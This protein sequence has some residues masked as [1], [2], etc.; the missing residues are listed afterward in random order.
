MCGCRICSSCHRMKRRLHPG[1][2]I[3]RHTALS[4]TEDHFSVLIF[5]ST[6]FCQAGKDLRLS[7]L[8][9]DPLDVPPGFMLVGV[10]S[11]S[12][13]ETLLVCAVD[14]RFL[15]DE[16]GRYALLGEGEDWNR[17]LV[18]LTKNQLKEENTEC[19]CAIQ[20][21]ECRDTQK[22]LFILYS[23]YCN[24]FFL[25][26]YPQQVS[27]ETVWAVERKVSAISQSSPITLTWSSTPSPRNRSTW[28]TI[29][30]ET[31]RACSSEELPS[32]GGEMVRGAHMLM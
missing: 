30:T 31:A 1:L 2:S 15:P 16:R 23:F 32:V 18:L 10:K 5:H 4:F 13:P 20:L 7:S 29:C 22:I 8:A 17:K 9:S 19:I 3:T 14:R 27:Q 24:N 26:W 21:C 25:F 12:L 6:G 11:P 28:S